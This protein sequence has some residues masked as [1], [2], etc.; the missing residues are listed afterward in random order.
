M[1][2]V[3]PWA[4]GLQSPLPSPGMSEGLG[5]WGDSSPSPVC[6]WPRAAPGR[7]Y[8]L[9]PLPPPLASQR[10]AF[11]ESTQVAGAALWQLARTRMIN[12]NGMRVGQ[13]QHLLHPVWPFQPCYQGSW[14][15]RPQ[16]SR[17]RGDRLQSSDLSWVRARE[18]G[19]LKHLQT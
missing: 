9:C 12:A 6:H 3:S 7:L 14:S 18:S 4:T 11:E 15:S 13:C 19:L 10:K 8:S 5:S 1:G 17:P 16:L 2:W